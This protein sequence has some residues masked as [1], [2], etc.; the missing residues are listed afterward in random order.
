MRPQALLG[1]TMTRI[2]SGLGDIDLH[3]LDLAGDGT[4]S[5]EA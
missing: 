2:L 1:E 3:P 5:R 4:H